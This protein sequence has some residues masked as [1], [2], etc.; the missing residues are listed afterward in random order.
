M[1]KYRAG[2]TTNKNMAHAHCMLGTEGYKYTHSGCVILIAFPQQRRLQERVS[3]L[4]CTYTVC[5]VEKLSRIVAF[6]M[7]REESCARVSS[8]SKALI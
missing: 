3:M 1:E 4:R 8:I 7:L 6:P 5:L 2:E